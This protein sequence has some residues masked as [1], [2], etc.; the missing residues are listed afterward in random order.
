VHLI[1]LPNGVQ[2]H[3]GHRPSRW[4]ANYANFHEIKLPPWWGES[5]GRAHWMS[6]R[7]FILP[8]FTDQV[9]PEINLPDGRPTSLQTHSFPLKSFRDVFGS[10]FSGRARIA[11]VAQHR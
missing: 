4:S 1:F 6:A 10:L 2:R 3:A 11:G 8:K 9:R 7:G 5:P